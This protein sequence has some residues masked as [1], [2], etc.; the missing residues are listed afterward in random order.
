MRASKSVPELMP[1]PVV[2]P[3]VLIAYAVIRT[4]RTMFKVTLAVK[5]PQFSVF[6]YFG[7]SK[8]VLGYFVCSSRDLPKTCITPSKT[9]K[10]T[11]IDPVT[12]T[13]L[14]LAWGTK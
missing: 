7:R 14:G 10:F 11:L 4:D 6:P 3:T 2:G 1:H 9:Q 5:V 8:S 12:S 13:G